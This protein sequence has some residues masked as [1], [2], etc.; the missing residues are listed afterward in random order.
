MRI[1]DRLLQLQQQQQKKKVAKTILSCGQNL[2]F[3]ALE[4]GDAV[5]GHVLNMD[6]WKCMIELSHRFSMFNKPIDIKA[7]GA[8]AVGIFMFI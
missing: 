8:E 1:D 5:F 2:S 4:A 7:G 3:S 6:Y